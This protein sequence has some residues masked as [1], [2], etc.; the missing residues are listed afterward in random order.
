M[1]RECYNSRSSENSIFLS[2]VVIFTLR[3]ADFIALEFKSFE[4]YK[5]IMEGWNVELKQLVGMVKIFLQDAIAIFQTLNV[6]IRLALRSERHVNVSR[7]L[8]FH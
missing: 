3:I 6:F 8:N 7:G 4:V 1:M 2:S 5:R